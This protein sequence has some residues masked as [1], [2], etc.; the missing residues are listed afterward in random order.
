MKKE[1]ISEI[2]IWSLVSILM[3]V[4][5]V[6]LFCIISE[7]S[8]YIYALLGMVFIILGLSLMC[9]IRDTITLRR[10]D[11]TMRNNSNSGEEN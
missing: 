6:V 5:I 1:I 8:F 10:L 2:V 7:F 9:V 4:V 3:L 11:K